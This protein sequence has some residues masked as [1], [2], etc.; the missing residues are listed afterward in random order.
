MPPKELAYPK[1]YYPNWPAPE[2]FTPVLRDR[3][4]D[5]QYLV[6]VSVGSKQIT[7]DFTPATH[8]YVETLRIVAWRI[9]QYLEETGTSIRRLESS[10]GLSTNTIY[11]VINGQRWLRAE[12]LAQLELHHGISLWPKLHEVR[13]GISTYQE[14]RMAQIK[15]YLVQQQNEQVVE[16]NYN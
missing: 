7:L 4:A 14:P 8:E 16:L 2:G 9:A 1:D 3:N 11:Y 10:S 15:Q 12:V 5:E 13:Q 6:T